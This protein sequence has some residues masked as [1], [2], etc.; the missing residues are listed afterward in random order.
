MDARG[1]SSS[2]Q[3]SPQDGVHILKVMSLTHATPLALAPKLCNFLDEQEIV[4]DISNQDI[5]APL[6]FPTRTNDWSAPPK[7]ISTHS[8]VQHHHCPQNEFK[9]RAGMR[10]KRN[11]NQHPPFSSHADKSPAVLIKDRAGSLHTTV[12]RLLRSPVNRR[13]QDQSPLQSPMEV[14]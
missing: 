7:T 2:G 9:N 3:D 6:Q 8:R 13:F 4:P 11:T 1:L 12:H 10:P 5:P 14:S